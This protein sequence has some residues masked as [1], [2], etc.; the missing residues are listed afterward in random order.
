MG[1]HGRAL[2]AAGLLIAISGSVRIRGS[3]SATAVWTI[4]K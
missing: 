3:H 1:A 4:G 2:S